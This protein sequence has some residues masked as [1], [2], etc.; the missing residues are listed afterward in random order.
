MSGILFVDD[1]S[2][3][4]TTGHMLV[5]FRSGGDEFRFHLPAHVAL[6]FREIVLRN[7][8]QVCCAPN[9]EVVALKP[10]RK[11]RKS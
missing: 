5:T 7:T 8:W 10:G 9:A 11:K 2:A 4:A 6:K 1:A 3:D